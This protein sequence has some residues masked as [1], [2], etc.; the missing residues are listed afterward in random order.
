MLSF[1]DAL[2]LIL[3]D[4]AADHDDFKN[5]LLSGSIDE[6]RIISLAKRNKISNINF[7]DLNNEYDASSFATFFTNLND[8][9]ILMVKYNEFMEEEIKEFF[10]NAINFRKLKLIIGEDEA[11]Q[12]VE[13]NLNEFNII[14][15]IDEGQDI[16]KDLYDMFSL[17]ITVGGS[18]FKIIDPSDDNDISVVTEKNSETHSGEFKIAKFYGA[19]DWFNAAEQPEDITDLPD[20]FDKA[21]KLWTQDKDKNIEKIINLIEPY[22]NANFVITALNDWDK[23]FVETEG[24]QLEAA[25]TKMKLVGVDFSENP[26]PQCK[27]EAWFEIPIY[28]YITNQEIDEWQDE[29]GSSLTDAL[30]FRWNID[31][32]D[33]DFSCGYNLGVEVVMLDN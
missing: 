2:N 33:L 10:Y 24:Y 20:D 27:A 22:L 1:F 3:D 26:I 13:I 19:M 7:L 6:K 18:N 21:Y 4:K 5:I 23:I 9:D 25:A 30:I 32:D 16:T 14:L 8:D 31:Q 29:S 11:A 12:L 15:S 17:K 28:N